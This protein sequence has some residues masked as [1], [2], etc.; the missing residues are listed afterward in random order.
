MKN[1]EQVRA[2]TYTKEGKSWKEC[3]ETTNPEAVYKK[4]LDDMISKKLN[5]CTYI[6][7]I[8]KV[9]LYNGFN[10]I[11]VYYDNGVKTDYIIDRA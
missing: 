2:T 5:A 4:L 1:N 9:N 3:H 7:K 6:R 8:E 11:T 10:R